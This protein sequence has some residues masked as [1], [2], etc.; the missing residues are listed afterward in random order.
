MILSDHGFL[1][2]TPT[3]CGTTTLEEMT[4]RHGGGRVSRGGVQLPSF[5]IASDEQPRRQ[6]RMVPPEGWQDVDRY[7]MVRN[8]FTRYMSQYEYLRAPHNYSKFGAKEIQGSAWLG[9]DRGR[10]GVV[11]E[12]MTFQQFLF[13]IARARRE[14][15]QRRWVKR[16]GDLYSPFAWRS[17]WIWLDPLDKQESVLDGCSGLGLGTVRRLRL[18]NF[19][20]EMQFLKDR[21]GL[22]T[23]SVKPSIRANKTLTYDARGPHHYWGFG[24][25]KKVFEPDGSFDLGRVS[26][27]EC[28][29]CAACAVGVVREAT[30]LGYVGNRA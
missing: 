27:F 25:T 17:P 9:W 18:E 29:R 23:L 6:H 20:E 11:G 12:P 4:R 13:F 10:A 19:W 22:K 8:P 5:R 3:K 2:A 14:Y 30:A 15:L 28:G 26:P 16:R 7:I 21:Y 1:I 24:C